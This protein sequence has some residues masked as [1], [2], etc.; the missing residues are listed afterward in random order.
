MCADIPAAGVGHT[1]RA[2]PLPK[3][4]PLVALATTGFRN[5]VGGVRPVPTQPTRHGAARG[6]GAT[7]IIWRPNLLLRAWRDS[8]T[9][10][11][12][13]EP[14]SCARRPSGGGVTVPS[15]RTG[16]AGRALRFT[17]SW[18]SPLPSFILTRRRPGSRKACSVTRLPALPNP[19]MQPTGRRCPGLRPGASSLEDEAERRFVRAPA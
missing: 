15:S 18:G 12:A 3:A 6:S 11:V 19:R 1:L 14:P 13:S 16:S 17:T 5:S 8:Q 2:R 10:L 4:S 9:W 7:R